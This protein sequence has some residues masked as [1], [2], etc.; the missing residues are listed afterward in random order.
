MKLLILSSVYAPNF[1]GGAEKIAQILAEGLHD[2]GHKPVV[3]T[4]DG[5]RGT[6][7]G[8]VNGV[9]VHYVGIRNLYWPRARY[10]PNPLLK[11][12]WHGLNS[13][14]PWMRHAVEPILHSEKPDVVHSHSLTG[15]SCSMWPLAK[16]RGVPVI[17]TL[18]DYS[19]MCPKA[20][21]YQRGVNCAGQCTVCRAYSLPGK[22]MSTHVDAVVGVSRHM[23]NQHLRAGY[24]SHAAVRRIIYNGLPSAPQAAVA[25]RPRA[26]APLRLGFVGRLTPNKGIGE[27]VAQ[28]H[29]WTGRCDLVV[30][31]TSPAGMKN[32]PGSRDA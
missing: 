11:P 32:S 20:S 24:F 7:I 2:R 29:E 22:L 26:G 6:R 9:K 23:L 17:H 28:M 3:V 5:G 15:L 12:L 8:H 19:L 1:I 25:A 18:H 16:Q 4:T 21:M 31:G 30:G 10:K 14:N 27:L 13:Y